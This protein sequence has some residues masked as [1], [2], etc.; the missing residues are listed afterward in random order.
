MVAFSMK[1]FVH[2]LRRRRTFRTAGF[3]IFGAWL[4][5]QAADVF[6]PGWGLP[7]TAINVLLATAIFGFPLVLVFGWFYDI[8]GNGIVRTPAAGAGDT[9][10]P[11]KRRDYAL[12]A[13]LGL[14]AA[15]IV[16]D[17]LQAVRT[18]VGDS[19]PVALAEQLESAIAVLPFANSSN[20]PA[21][22]AF[23][24]GIAEQILYKL[25]RYAELTVIGRT[26][27]FTFKDSD[28]RIPDIADLLGARYLL[29]GSVRQDG[30]NLRITAALVDGSGAQLW[31]N[32][33]DRKLES[34]FAIQD[35]IADDVANTVVPKIAARPAANYQPDIGAYQQYL[36]GR[37]LLRQR[38]F[39]ATIA[40]EKAVE[41]DP[42]FAAA[43]AELAIAQL[44][45]TPDRERSAQAIQSALSLQPGMPRALA[46]RGLFLTLQT[47]PDYVAAEKVLREALAKEPNDV[48]ALNWLSN[49]L[50]GQDK[51]A[52]S[53]DV[54]TQAARID[55]LHAVV[56]GNLANAYH[57][58]GE[59]GRAEQLLA[60]LLDVPGQGR[61]AYNRMGDIYTE[62]GQIAKA[63]AME[64][65]LA[66]SGLHAYYG[67]AENYAMLGMWDAAERWAMLTQEDFPDFPWA[68]LF[69]AMVP[70]WQGRYA[71]AADE[72]RAD[73]QS[74]ETMQSFSGYFYAEFQAQAGRFSGAIQTMESLVGDAS[75][76]PADE[77][78]TAGYQALAWAYLESDRRV[79][80]L[81]ILEPIDQAYAALDHSGLL[82]GSTDLFLYAQNAL[83]LGNVDAAL[84]RLERAIDA[85]WRR[86]FIKHHDPRWKALENNPRYVALMEPVI[87]DLER[88]RA[89]VE[90]IDANGDFSERFENVRRLRP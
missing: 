55:P 4:L 76:A 82:H 66:L 49:A 11:L 89:E 44:I 77:T 14:I 57:E 19:P 6:F 24:D 25:S 40:F 10:L 13:A 17:G 43:H 65:R 33:Y 67:L 37:D 84:D 74:L 48:D 45:L 34:I 5:M 63:N 42:A 68:E 39:G 27:S 23:C 71:T 72:Y 88:Q 21:N 22:E 86:Y 32:V 26:S 87:A 7:D 3:Y 52:E 83:L 35:E 78:E 61:F 9:P 29:Q 41:I 51:Q 79:E 36:I 8:T 80:A 81:R 69:P 18:S 58:R 46:A 28:Y 59:S 16:Y 15:I 30:N 85:G 90:R 56:V 70:A 50:G 38:S 31:S 1:G 54:I 2:E 64:K 47:P 62:T 53:F 60:P 20:D 12:L 73:E 75:H